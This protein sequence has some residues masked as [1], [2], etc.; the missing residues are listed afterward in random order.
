VVS[1]Y[2]VVMNRV[3]GCDHTKLPTIGGLSSGAAA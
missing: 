1:V 2:S 3:D